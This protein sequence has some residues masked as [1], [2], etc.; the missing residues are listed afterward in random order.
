[1]RNLNDP[2]SA[3]F[4]QAWLIHTN[5]W[6]K[7]LRSRGLS[8]QT[9]E[10]RFDHISMMARTF[11]DTDPMEITVGQLLDWL[12]TT[13]W[14]P[15]TRHSYYCSFRGFFRHCRPE[16][17]HIQAAFPS[18]RRRVPPPRPCPENIFNQAIADADERTRLVLLLAGVLGLRAGE[19]A[20]VHITDISL[21][22]M[23]YTL[24][25]HGKGGKQRDIPLPNPLACLIINRCSENGGYCF[26]GKKYAHI[27]S[28]RL[29][30]TATEFLPPPWTLHTLRHRFATRAYSAE[31]DLL[32]LQQLLGHESVAT[33]QR[34]AKPPPE[35]IYKAINAALPKQWHHAAFL[36]EGERK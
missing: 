27:T 33:T 18:I 30:K 23:G 11:A 3:G 20:R 29:S 32:T 22:L 17:V 14:K 13:P 34:Y 36:N 31:R 15:E 1:M 26:P 21:D 4:P 24:R 12:S 16:D 9:V 19:I 8:E 5:A 35:A 28:H 2:R 7:V 25:I 10:K 6:L